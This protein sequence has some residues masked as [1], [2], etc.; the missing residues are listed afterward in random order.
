MNQQPCYPRI[1]QILMGFQDSA[2]RS[3][4]GPSD[5]VTDI[6]SPQQSS[7]NVDTVDS[8]LVK[9]E[10]PSDDSVPPSQRCH[11]TAAVTSANYENTVHKERSRQ[12]AA[13]FKRPVQS[14]PLLMTTDRGSKT[15]ELSE[16]RVEG[17]KIS[18]FNVGGEARLCLPQLLSRVLYSIPPAALQSVTDALHVHFA[19]CGAGQLEMLKQARVLPASVPRSGLVTLTDALRICAILLHDHPPRHA[20]PNEMTVIPVLHECFGGCRG[21]F[22]PGEY[23]SPWSLCIECLECHGRLSA[24]QFISHSHTSGESRTCHWGF[25]SRKWRSYLMVSDEDMSPD[26][27]MPLQKLLDQMKLLF[28][29]KEAHELEQVITMNI[30]L[31]IVI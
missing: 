14:A 18:C 20:T 22:W 10:V 25:D 12:P 30:C 21:L 11:V 23:Q 4:S 6:C 16:T 1:K 19:E 31:C 8:F 2:K 26:D 17:E 9:P 3:L 27:Q 29:G 7:S 24:E 28:I 15:L 13:G 5:T